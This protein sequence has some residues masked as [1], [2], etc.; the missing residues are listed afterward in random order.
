MSGVLHR[1]NPSDNKFLP[2]FP[3]GAWEIK[4]EKKT[5]IV[6]VVAIFLSFLINFVAKLPNIENEIL[7]TFPVKADYVN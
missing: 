4:I 3:N 5:D 6:D 7:P 2:L 1:H